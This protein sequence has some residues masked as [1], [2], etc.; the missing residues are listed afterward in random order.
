[1]PNKRKLTEATQS[2]QPLSSPLS[3]FAVIVSFLFHI[4]HSAQDHYE[5]KHQMLPRIAVISSLHLPKFERVL[6]RSMIACL[7]GLFRTERLAREMS[8]VTRVI[9][10]L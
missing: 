10:I 3:R 2:I 9:D 7:L 5:S 6:E 8:A 1:M 4:S